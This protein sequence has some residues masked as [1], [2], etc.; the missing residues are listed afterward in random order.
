MT[1]FEFILLLISLVVIIS[2]A[3]ACIVF[4]H[5]TNQQRKLHKTILKAQNDREIE[6]YRVIA[7]EYLHQKVINGHLLPHLIALKE[8]NQ[9]VGY[10]KAVNKKAFIEKIEDLM[11]DIKNTE[12]IVRNIS[13]NIFPPHLTDFFAESCQQHLLQLQKKY[14][15]EGKIVFET[16]GNFRELAHLQALLFNLY[17]LIDLFVTNSIKHAKASVIDVKLN[18]NNNTVSLLMEDNGIGF[19]IKEKTLSSSG[20]GI[21]DFIGRAMVLSSNQYFESKAMVGTRFSIHVDLTKFKHAVI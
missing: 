11:K 15:Y 4:L 14:H 8:L 12:S 5:Y 17:T 19:S 3:G 6:I 2:V 21:A 18:F 16:E 20:R 13:E 1:K 7:S 10:S 9:L